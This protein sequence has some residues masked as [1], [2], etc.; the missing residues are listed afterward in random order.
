ME[1]LKRRARAL[2]APRV[3]ETKETERP[4]LLSHTCRR[5]Q[6]ASRTRRHEL[7]H[8]D[9]KAHVCDVAGCGAR[10]K[11]PHHL[12][13]HAAQHA[14]PKARPRPAPCCR[15]SSVFY[16]QQYS[17]A[18]LG[19]ARTWCGSLSG[20]V[21]MQCAAVRVHRARLQQCVCEAL[22]LGQAYGGA[23]RRAQVPMRRG[24]LHGAVR[25]SGV[26]R[27]YLDCTHATLHVVRD[28]CLSDVQ[29]S[30]CHRG[31]RPLA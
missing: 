15:P 21:G 18:S 20:G 25:F 8:S 23:P 7:Q 19:K 5:A 26:R 10:F 3:V 28:Q 22:W 4:T 31:H 11:L 14:N 24:G 13:R 27:L 2:P 12:K 1:H 9:V 30:R 17:S 29:R 16:G 6:P